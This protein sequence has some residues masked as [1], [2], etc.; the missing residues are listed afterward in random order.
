VVKINEQLAMNNPTEIIKSEIVLENHHALL[1]PLSLDFLD[2]L[3]EI[4]LDKSL[5]ALGMSRI[6]NKTDLKNYIQKALKERSAGQS[7]PFVIF[8][9]L[10]N[11]CAGST[12]YGN[13]SMENR[14]VEIGWT[15]IGKDFQGTGLNKACK[16][17]LLKFAFEKLECNRVE[18]KT[19]ALNQQSRKAMEKIGASFEGLLR[20]HQITS[21]GRIRDSVYYSII[22]SEWPEIKAALFF[23]FVK[24]L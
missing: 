21:T 17:E 10:K 22:A 13:I 14:R 4:A 18:L 12:R 24:E 23:E 7:Y 8:D 20:S 9:K 11:R 3:S 6:E 5:W 15:W 19:D 16:F 1:K 2:E